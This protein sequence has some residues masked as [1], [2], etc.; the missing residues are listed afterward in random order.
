[1]GLFALMVAVF[2]KDLP[3]PKKVGLKVRKSK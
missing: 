3:Q 2:P 1:M